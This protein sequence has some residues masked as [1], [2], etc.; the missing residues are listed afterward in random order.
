M[1]RIR[2]RTRIY[3]GNRASAG[4]RALGE[5]TG[6]RVLRRSGTRFR[7]RPGDTIINWG[8]TGEVPAALHDATWINHP[9]HVRNAVDKRECFYTLSNSDIPTP[10][11]CTD[12]ETARGWLEDGSIV[13]AR[14]LVNASA[15]RG[16]I[17]VRPG[18]VLPRVPL[19]TKYFR[20]YDEYRIHVWRGIP[21]DAQQKRRRREVGDAT[22]EVRNTDNGWVF[23]R[24]EVSP[25]AAAYEAAIAAVEAL[26]LDFGAIDIKCNRHHGS[27]VVLECNTAPGLEGTT[28][29]RYRSA[30][31]GHAS[32]VRAAGTAHDDGGQPVRVPAD[33]G[34]AGEFVEEAGD[35]FMF[36]GER[37]E[38]RCLLLSGRPV[39]VPS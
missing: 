19:Y 29:A 18:E 20:G 3:R 34:D 10:E 12:G 11:W 4:A 2:N 22:N 6:I 37:F 35:R 31:A 5:A 9:Y 27:V 1:A 15:G 33:V 38:R 16:L 26:G 28:L 39:G 24:E 14:R 17:V 7:A 21:F 32:D 13:M 30:V 36:A 23:C 25:P 8:Y